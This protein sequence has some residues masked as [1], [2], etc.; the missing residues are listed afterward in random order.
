CATLSE[1]VAS[2]N[3]WRVG[4]ALALKISSTLPVVPFVVPFTVRPITEAAVGAI[5]FCPAVGTFTIQSEQ[6]LAATLPTQLAVFAALA[7]K[8]VLPAVEFGNCVASTF[9]V[10]DP[11]PFVTL[12][13]LAVPV[14][15]AFVS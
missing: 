6:V 4:V 12:K 5:T 13:R 1:P 3:A 2:K 14:S 8:I 10:I 9:N 7:I 11:P 15:V